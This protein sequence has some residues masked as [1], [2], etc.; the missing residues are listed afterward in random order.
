MVLQDLK[1]IAH[2]VIVIKEPTYI[3]IRSLSSIKAFASF[4]PI[5]VNVVP[6]PIVH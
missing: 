1:G 2:S 5:V 4:A 6:K 3:L